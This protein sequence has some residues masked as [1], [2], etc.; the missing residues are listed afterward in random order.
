MT[1]PNFAT[2]D[3]NPSQCD[4]NCV[5]TDKNVWQKTAES[6]TKLDIVK[7]MEGIDIAPLYT[8]SDLDGLVHPSFTAGISPNL[9]GPYPTMYVSRP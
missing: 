3:F 9:R 6:Q 7:S 8:K 2:M 1:F 4:C 5:N